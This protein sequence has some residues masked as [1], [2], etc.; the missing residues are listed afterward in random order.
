MECISGLIPNIKIPLRIV[1]KEHVKKKRV[2]IK[3][4]K[5]DEGEEYFPDTFEGIRSKYI[6][7]GWSISES[8]RTSSVYILNLSPQC[9]SEMKMKN[10]N[11]GSDVKGYLYVGMTGL[12][13]EERI[14][15]H[16]SGIKSCKLVSKYFQ[17]EFGRIGGLFHYEA[18]F[19]EGYLPG[20]LRDMGFW[21]YQA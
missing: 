11:T 9:R 18:E 21:V 8:Q 10:N 12:S 3:I 19:I 14:N 20:V 15:N 6:S 5:G 1:I 4:V 16:V 7:E 2:T 13:V 17:G